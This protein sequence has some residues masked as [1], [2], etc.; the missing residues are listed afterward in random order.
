MKIL[1][2]LPIEDNTWFVTKWKIFDNCFKLKIT[3]LVCQMSLSIKMLN[4]QMIES[5]KKLK[6]V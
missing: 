4:V 2:L 1:G 5:H 6:G 3:W